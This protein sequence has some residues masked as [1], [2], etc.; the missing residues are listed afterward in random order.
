MCSFFCR[1]VRF[2]ALCNRQ[3]K[4]VYPEALV[5]QFSGGAA[6]SR[7]QL[8]ERDPALSE[9]N[10]HP[11]L[12]PCTAIQARFFQPGPLRNGQ[13]CGNRWGGGAHVRS[14]IGDG[15]IGFVTDS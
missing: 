14:E 9:T 4:V 11:C 8:L 5:S 3:E 6:E 12:Q 15:G 2:V 7:C 1:V 13:F 10:R